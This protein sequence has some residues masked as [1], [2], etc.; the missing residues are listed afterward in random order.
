MDIGPFLSRQRP[1]LSA[2]LSAAVHIHTIHNHNAL[3]QVQPKSARKEWQDAASTF[4][5]LIGF[6]PTTRFLR[7]DLGTGA[8][9]RVRCAARGKHTPP[10]PGFGTGRKT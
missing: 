7:A 1:V 8:R 6:T 2:V 5:V 4:L 9:L 3:L 10:F